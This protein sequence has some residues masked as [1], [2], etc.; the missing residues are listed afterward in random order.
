[1]PGTIP[2]RKLLY[3]LDHWLKNISTELTSEQWK[4]QVKIIQVIKFWFN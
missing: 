4:Y 2:M 1:M 3:R